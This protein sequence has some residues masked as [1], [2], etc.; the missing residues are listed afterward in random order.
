MWKTYWILDLGD[1]LLEKEMRFEGSKAGYSQAC[2]CL[3]DIFSS[4]NNLGL[5]VLLKEADVVWESI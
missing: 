3:G 5:G 1:R 2:M 4:V